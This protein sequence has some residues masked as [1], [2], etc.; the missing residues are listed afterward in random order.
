MRLPGDAERA[1]LLEVVRLSDSTRPFTSRGLAGDVVDV[2]VEDEAAQA[3]ALVAAL[4]DSPRYRCFVPGWGLR[5]YDAVDPE[6][7]LE[8]A[9]C[10]RC[11]GAR[12]QGRDVPEDMR[13]QDFAGESPPGRELLH[14][15]RACA[16][17]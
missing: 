9:F 8:I 10:F 13:F 15:F 5:L 6:P 4:P 1:E 7:F 3:L 14:R 12:V 11:N 16:P 17:S 2:W